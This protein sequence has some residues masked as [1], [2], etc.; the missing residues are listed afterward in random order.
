MFRNL[1]IV[2]LM[3]VMVIAAASGCSRK[4]GDEILIGIA[5]PMTGDQSKMGIDFKNGVQLAVDEWNAKGGVLG[6]KVV[7]SVEDDQHDPKQAVAI[8]NKLV[9][10]GVAGVVGHFNSS[11][12]IPASNIYMD[13]GV[14]MITPATTNPEFT[15][16]GMWNVFRVCGRDDQQGK[17]AADFVTG[18][19]G[20]K[21]VAVLHDKTTYGQGLAGQFKANLGPAVEVVYYGSIIQGD[22]DFKSVLTSIKSNP[23]DVLYFGGIYPEGGLLVKQAREIGLNSVL[24]G[25]DGIIDQK[26]IEIGGESAEGSYITFSPDPE[27]IPTAKAFLDEYHKRY[28]QHGPYSVYAYD[29]ANILLKAI[30]E[31]GSTDGKAVAGHIRDGSFV[32]A[33]GTVS[34]DSKGD[35]KVANYVIWQ[36]KGGRFVQV[37]TL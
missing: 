24:V 36:V 25:G 18:T 12:S 11:C 17:A 15:E 21:K 35:N 22:K 8:A 5:G 32:G 34:F 23:P 6:K 2:S 13:G 27:N 16:R 20:A 1:L 7:V 19:L 3:A 31:T 4:P 9:N 26:F 30:D 37:T 10:D 33:L 28:G 29:A 14:P